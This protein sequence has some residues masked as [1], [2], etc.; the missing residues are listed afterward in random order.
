MVDSYSYSNLTKLHIF[1]FH[2]LTDFNTTM[3]TE[4]NQSDNT[5]QLS[6]RLTEREVFTKIW[7]SPREVFRYINDYRFDKYQTAF[8]VLAGISR[9][10]DRASTRNMG[11]HESLGMIIFICIIA[12]A[13]AGWMT[14]YFYAALVS[15]TGEWL[16][17]K[18][19]MESIVRVLSFAVLPSILSLLLLIPQIAIY[20]KAIFQTNGDITSAS[21]MGNI[22]FYGSILLDFILAAYSIVFAIIGVSEVQK[23]SIGKTILNLLMPAII[24][25]VPISIIVMIYNYF[26]HGNLF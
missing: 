23:L 17:G 2:I 9:A 1:T 14:Y 18:G 25:I 19:N 7:T 12:G 15:W 24:I 26:A 22:I 3:E 11:D 21:L 4:T 13:V 5:F 16:K 20:G 6:P 8:L 10:F